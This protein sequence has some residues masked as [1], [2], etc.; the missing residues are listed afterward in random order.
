[1]LH[2]QQLSVV[3]VLLPAGVDQPAKLRPA[4]FQSVAH[5]ATARGEEDIHAL[6]LGFQRKRREYTTPPLSAGRGLFDEYGNGVIG[7]F[8]RLRVTLQQ[9]HMQ[10]LAQR[11]QLAIADQVLLD[12]LIK[13]R[14][15]AIPRVQRR[16]PRWKASISVARFCG[17]VS[18]L[19]SASACR[20]AATRS[21]V[22]LGQRLQRCMQGVRSHGWSLDGRRRFGDSR[23]LANLC[24]AGV[25]DRP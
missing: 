23:T 4:S 14:Q 13:C 7:I 15:Q 2:C 20:S 5:F 12:I 11:Q 9:L 19:P 8:D 3:V 16:L 10:R 6:L 25:G 24:G 18:R 17:L 21:M 22:H 1:M